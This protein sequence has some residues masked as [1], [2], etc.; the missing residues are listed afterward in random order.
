MAEE[1]KI[2]DWTNTFNQFLISKSSFLLNDQTFYSAGQLDAMQEGLVADKLIYGSLQSPNYEPGKTGWKID[3]NGLLEIGAVTYNKLFMS[4]SFESF[5][6][7]SVTAGVFSYVNYMEID[8]TATATNNQYSRVP[9]DDEFGLYP[10][11]TK[12]PVFEFYGAVSGTT[13]MDGYAGM[14]ELVVDSGI[15]FHFTS[16]TVKAIWY[17]TDTVAHEYDLSLTPTTLRLYRVEATSNKIKFFVNGVLAYTAVPDGYTL[18]PGT[19]P[20]SFN[21][22]TNTNTVVKLLVYRVLFYQDL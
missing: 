1:L 20:I 10:N 6:G 15:G 4:P 3:K 13:S 14:G 18:T 19:Y 17:D 7:W 5:D 16:T 11:L 12:N 8:T 21:I 9:Q 2:E 22:T